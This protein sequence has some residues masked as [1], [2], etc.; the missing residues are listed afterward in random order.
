MSICRFGSDME[1]VFRPFLLM[2]GG[3]GQFPWPL[4][5]APSPTSV[6]ED[7]KNLTIWAIVR[8]AP[9]HSGVESFSD[10]NMWA[11]AQLRA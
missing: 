3:W 7:I 2:F 11:P 10:K 5:I 9:F 6:S 4:C 1:I 8:I